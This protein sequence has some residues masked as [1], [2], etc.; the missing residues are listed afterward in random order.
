MAGLFGGKD[1]GGNRRRNHDDSKVVTGG[2]D[3]LHG[4]HAAP[5]EWITVPPGL[6]LTTATVTRPG[7]RFGEGGG[8]NAPSERAARRRTILGGYG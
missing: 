5:S 3:P 8:L 2:D 1:G 4:V 6:S 7:E